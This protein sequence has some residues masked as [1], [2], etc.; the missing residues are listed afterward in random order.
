MI[1]PWDF[2]RWF[3]LFRQKSGLREFVDYVVECIRLK[4]DCYVSLFS[5]RQIEEKRYDAILID[6]DD[7]YEAFQAADVLIREDGFDPVWFF[8][9]R[10]YHGYIFFEETYMPDYSQRVKQWAREIGIIELVDRK[11][12]GDAMRM[13]RVPGTWN[14]KGER[15]MIP[16]TKDTTI[17]EIDELSR[18]PPYVSIFGEPERTEFAKR[19]LGV[20]TKRRS[21]SNV[22]GAIVV[23]SIPPCIEK[24]M[25]YARESHHLDHEARLL[26]GTFL[27]RTRGFDAALDFFRLMEDFNEDVTRYQLEWLIDNDYYPHS[28]KT[29]S[30]FGMCPMRCDFYPWIGRFLKGVDKDAIRRRR[31]DAV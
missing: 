25:D 29:I 28:C 7:G 11:V 5:E 17:D 23:D 21:V 1:R 14:T 4:K 31:G 9:G 26:V 13:R 24:L 20:E 27:L 8:S 2:P 16:I 10:G 22:D 15:W 30:D 18:I 12:L 3:G 19:L 6:I